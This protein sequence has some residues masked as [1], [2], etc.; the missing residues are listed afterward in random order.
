MKE[1]MK[2]WQREDDEKVKKIER[3]KVRLNN[4]RFWKM[5][6]CRKRMKYG[7]IKDRKKDEKSRVQ[8]EERNVSRWK[9]WKILK[10]WNLKK[11]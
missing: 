10:E 4:E 9:E 8:K 5:N 1:W 11:E 2:V 6:K 7:W 3:I